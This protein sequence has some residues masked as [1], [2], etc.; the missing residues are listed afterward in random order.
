MSK[1]ARIERSMSGTTY[2]NANQIIT[3]RSDV[4]DTEAQASFSEAQYLRQVRD[5]ISLGTIENVIYAHY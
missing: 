3:I 1:N 4:I 5:Q 2:I